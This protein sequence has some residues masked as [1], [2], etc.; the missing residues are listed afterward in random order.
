MKLNLRIALTNGTAALL[1]FAGSVSTTTNLRGNLL[2]AD[3]SAS[4]AV[5]QTPVRLSEQV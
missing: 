1:A 4:P 3:L 5:R 2:G